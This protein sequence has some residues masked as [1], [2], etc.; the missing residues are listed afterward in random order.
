VF[1]G[2][3]NIGAVEIPGWFSGWVL[4]H[5]RQAAPAPRRSRTGR[6]HRV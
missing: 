1:E 4:S 3:V 5:R 6:N 2:P